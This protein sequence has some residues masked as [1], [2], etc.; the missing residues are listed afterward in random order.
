[1]KKN[2]IIIDYHLGNL[3]SVK[4]AFKK[5]NLDISISSNEDKIQNADAL[6]LPGVGA[7]KEAMTN[8]EKYNL[9][10]VIKNFIISGKPF[11]GVCL[12]LQLLFEESNEFENSKGL[13]IIKGKVSKLTFDSV[14]NIKIPHIGW[15][16][17]YKRNINDWNNTPLQDLKN[18]TDMYFVHSYHV[19]PLDESIISSYTNYNDLIFASSI[20]KDNIFACQF[21]PEKSA[22]EGLDIYS[23]WI[24]IHNL[25]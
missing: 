22:K 10:N 12:G 15:N 25:K 5:L 9:I 8:L 7:F 19:K 6:I 2:I 17:I 14:N 3:Y 20:K 13:G 1:M 11:M 18:G 21:H 16:S 4:N 24:K 23:N